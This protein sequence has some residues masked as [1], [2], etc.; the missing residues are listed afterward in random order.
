[1][2]PEEI[3]DMVCDHFKVDKALVVGP[4]G[5][6]EIC[7]IRHIYCLL[8]NKYTKSSLKEIASCIGNR[9]HTTIMHSIN[10]M[11]DL[12]TR[13][14]YYNEI[15]GSAEDELFEVFMVEKAAQRAKR[16]VMPVEKNIEPVKWQR[17]KGEY[18]NPQIP[19]APKKE[20]KEFKQGSIIRPMT[21]NL[22]HHK[23]IVGRM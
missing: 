8:C 23:K 10:T 18:T 13:D 7:D 19:L 1:M 9:D 2:T 4:R 15:F 6:Q 20:H 3:L 16:V 11:S 5:K 17:P 22:K 12:I 21:L 14:E